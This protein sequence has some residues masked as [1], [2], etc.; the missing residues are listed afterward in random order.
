MYSLPV[1][2][3]KQILARVLPEL[4][5]GA[6]EEF[7]STQLA[8]LYTLS[9][10]D[11]RKLLLSFAPSLAVR[12]LRHEA[13]M[14]SSE[15]TLVQ[16]ISES[17]EQEGESVKSE[18]IDPSSAISALPELV[19]KILK[20]SSNNREMAYPYSIFESLPG[21][22]LSTLSVYL[23]IP[24]RR[25]IDHQVGYMVR[26][27][28][29]LTS[30]SGTF[31]TVN[32]VLSDPHSTVVS[33]AP[34]STGSKTWSEAFGLLLEGILRDG[35]DMAVLLPYDTLRSYYHRLSWHLD[36]VMLPRLLVLD[37]GSEANLMIER[38]SEDEPYPTPDNSCRLTGLRSWSQGVFGDPLLCNCFDEPS[39]A[40]LE[41]WREEGKNFIEDEENAEIRLLL[42]RCFR[43]VV[44]IVTEYYRPQGDSSRRELEG[45]R[46][47]TSA[48]AA[49]ETLDVPET[50]K[51]QRS[52]SGHS[53][54]SESENSKRVKVDR[55]ENSA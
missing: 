29:K 23:S 43:A 38:S 20:H 4:T 14:L 26:N 17:R 6:V 25:Q 33:T 24:E 18:K 46:Q 11:G 55:P 50:L 10:S 47:L 30:P 48:L 42:Y 49:L 8:R 2:R 28:A 36:A 37:A 31:G 53:Q 52:H 22:P 40:F 51:R 45:R 19:P 13:T 44:V 35:E 39:K 54:G 16:F 32:R 27:L 3:L 15:A 12:L 21:A 41:G 34:E 7:P 9:M 5:L 1:R